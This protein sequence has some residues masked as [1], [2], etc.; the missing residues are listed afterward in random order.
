[1]YVREIL[2]VNVCERLKR[3]VADDASAPP[4]LNVADVVVGINTVARCV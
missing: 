2:C 4:S 3:V 1:M